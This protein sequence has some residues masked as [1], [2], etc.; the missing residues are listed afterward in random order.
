[1]DCARCVSLGDAAHL[2]QLLLLLELVLPQTMLIVSVPQQEVQQGRW[3][4]NHLS[5]TNRLS[6]NNTKRNYNNN[7]NNNKAKGEVQ[8]KVQVGALVLV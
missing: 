4:N 1:M 8:I 3:D 2:L 5:N 6:S 7:N